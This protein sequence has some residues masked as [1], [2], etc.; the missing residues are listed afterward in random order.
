MAETGTMAD[1]AT[2][3][4]S[5]QTG[6]TVHFSPEDL[7]RLCVRN[8]LA[9]AGERVFFK[10][11]QSRFLLVSA[12]FRLDEAPGG[13]VGQVVGKSDFDL[14]SSEHASEAF[15]DEQRIIETGEPIVGKVERETFH[16]RPDAWVVTTKMPL[17]DDE[18]RTVGTFGIRA[19]SR[20]RSWLKRRSAK[21][22]SVSAASSTKRRLGFSA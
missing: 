12:G 17:R 7:E 22:R 18:G 2:H 15:A 11:L 14:F 20:H 8:L 16:D 4:G 1:V 13:G 5:A 9:C 3:A 19:T 21:A 10:D 6:S